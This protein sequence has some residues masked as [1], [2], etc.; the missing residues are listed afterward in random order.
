MNSLPGKVVR[1]VF[2]GAARDYVVVLPDQTHLRVTAAPDVDLAPGSD[3]TLRLPEARC[4]LLS[5]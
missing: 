5:R 3:L 2:L 4:R 1:N